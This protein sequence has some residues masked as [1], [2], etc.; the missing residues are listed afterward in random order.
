MGAKRV[1]LLLFGPGEGEYGIIRVEA[2]RGKD[3]FCVYN[4]GNFVDTWGTVE[5][6]S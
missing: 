2:F 5:G 4:R 6:E 3:N 1:A